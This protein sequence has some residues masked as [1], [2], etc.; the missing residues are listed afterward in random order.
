MSLRK[1]S[2]VSIVLLQ[3]FSCASP[4]KPTP[5]IIVLSKAEPISESPL[6]FADSQLRSNGL[7]EE[8]IR[9]IHEKYID[10][11][12]K[13]WEDSAS[14]IIEL[15]VF[16]F[17]YHSNYAIHDTPK[18][19]TKIQSYLKKHK[20][21]FRLAWKKYHVDPRV[22]ASLIWV[23]TKLGKNTGGFHLPWVYY[24]LVLGSDPH[25]TQKMLELLPSK[26]TPERMKD[27][28]MEAAQKKVVERCK[29]KSLWSIDEL[30]ALQ[31]IQSNRD[32]NPFDI[33]A[34]FAG[35][36]GASQFIPST[37]LKNSISNFRK[38]PDLFKDS[39]AIL[40]V[41]HFLNENGW[42]DPTPDA[43]TK[44]LYAYNHSKDYG[45][46]ILKISQKLPRS[47]KDSKHT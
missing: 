12:K 22:V 25:F 26:A 47:F 34:S 13:N 3:S 31:E 8:F 38:K 10:H 9:S 44:A 2:L 1:L 6:Q 39:D 21:S 46:V 15:N 5:E 43:E 41:A 24:S 42:N 45:A 4:A 27:L 18:A 36:F 32:F 37:Y 35:A 33:K 14:A 28:S 20:S 23:E 16:G 40:S 30:K 19:Q 17:L 7:S 29:S 11:N